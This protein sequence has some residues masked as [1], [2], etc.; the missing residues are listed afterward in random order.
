MKRWT[1]ARS[2]TFLIAVCS[3]VCSSLAV[4]QSHE[5]SHSASRI[6]FNGGRAYQYAQDLVNCGPRWIGSQG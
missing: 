4:A 1:H 6:A 5:H 3:L 2:L